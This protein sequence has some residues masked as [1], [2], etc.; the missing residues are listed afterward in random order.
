MRVLIVENNPIIAEAVEIAGKQFRLEC[1]LATDGWEAIDKLHDE[2]YA[3]IVIDTDLPRRSGFGVLA[4]LR[5]ENGDRLDHVILMTSDRDDVRRR[6][7]NDRLQVIR[8][9]E[10]V[11]EIAAAMSAAFETAT[12][13]LL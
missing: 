10:A 7:G 2:Q 3:A 6:C 9:T 12:P 5:E 1:D 8:K 13:R 4:Y 11:D